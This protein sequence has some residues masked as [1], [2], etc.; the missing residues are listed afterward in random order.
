[1]APFKNLLPS[2]QANEIAQQELVLEKLLEA[3]R[4]NN[5]QIDDVCVFDVRV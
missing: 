3:W 5:E 1:M 4:G 2:I